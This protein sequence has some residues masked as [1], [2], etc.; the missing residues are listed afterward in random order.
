MKVNRVVS[1]IDDKYVL[2]LLVM[3]YSAQNNR[4]KDF[5]MILGYDSNKLSV[6]NREMISKCFEIFDIPVHFQSF[7]LNSGF[8]DNNHISATSFGRLLIYDS[9]PGYVLWL[10]ADLICLP[11][12]DQIFADYEYDIAETVII[13]ARD[14]FTDDDVFLNSSKNI[15][16]QLM[17]KNYFNTGVSLVNCDLWRERG[18]SEVWP[19]LQGNYAENGFQFSDQCVTNYA[20]VNHYKHLDAKYNSF[21]L[22]RIRNLET[23]RRILHFAGPFKPWQFT[24][25]SPRVHFS[26]LKRSDVLLYLKIQNEMIE[27][28][29]LSD[30]QVGKALVKY[31]H[32]FV[33]EKNFYRFY[34]EIVINLLNRR[35][36]GTLLIQIILRLKTRK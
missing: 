12:W 35:K 6:K 4:T 16:I 27:R 14:M 10:D 5:E 3:A 32:Y 11:A 22:S 21:A 15:A 31:S 20:C 1:A 36:S 29:K 8:A 34:K 26:G 13:A 23:E 19:L 24:K 18:I 7:S 28:I 33:I 30:D 17:G 25:L 2:P 9:T